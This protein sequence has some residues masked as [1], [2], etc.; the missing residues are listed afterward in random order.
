VTF[1]KVG[2]T[3]WRN[4]M[5]LLRV[6]GERVFRE[7]EHL[8]Y[9]APDG[10]AGSILNLELGTEYE[11]RF[12]L[13]DPDGVTGEAVRTVRVRT[14]TE[15]RPFAGGR[16][17]GN[18]S[19]LMNDDFVET[20]GGVH[21]VRVFGNRGV[22]AAMGGY[23]AQPVFGGPA[24][25]Y[26][27]L[28][29]HVP[30]G[31]AFKFSANAA[32]LIVAHNT[33]V[34]ENSLGEPTANMHLHNNL[35]LGSDAPGRGVMQVAHATD[36]YSSDHDR[37]RPTRGVEEQY[38][39][40]TPARG[41]RSCEPQDEKWRS[42]S[43]LGDLARATGLERHGIEVDYDVFADLAPPDATRVDAVHHAM[44]LTFALKPGSKAIDA[45]VVLPTINDD[46]S[47][48]G[49]DL[50]AIETSR[51][52]PRYGPEWLTWQPFYR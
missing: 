15:P 41:G 10:F 31:I 33:I 40:V 17:H 52:E 30:S 45:G 5:P 28:L 20:D 35:F 18:D 42:F 3:A 34:S 14:R 48:R 49:P 50:G 13:A 6:G 1:R 38:R 19:H 44:D 47:G 37:Y 4:A 36:A 7:R 32:G 23:S 12:E 39:V 21:N 46:F 2:D 29:Y 24:Y 16:T 43:T 22:N 9:T 8:D 27:N 26:R 25:F 51:P 11:C